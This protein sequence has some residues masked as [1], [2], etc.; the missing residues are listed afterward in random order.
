MRT[1]AFGVG[2]LLL[3]CVP[4]YGEAADAWPALPETD[5]ECLLPAQAWPRQPGPREVKVYIRYPGGAL[6]QVGQLAQGLE[7]KPPQRAEQPLPMDGNM[8]A[9]DVYAEIGR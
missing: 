7:H 9:E 6:A 3:A 1:L 5:A 8:Q 4:G 2:C